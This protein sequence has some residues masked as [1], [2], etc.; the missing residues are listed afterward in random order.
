MRIDRIGRGPLFAD[1]GPR[2][3]RI[4]RR[5]RGVSIELLAFALTTL[6]LP[7]LVPIAL[8]VD[9]VLWVVRRKPW[10]AIRLLAIGW[11]FLAVEIRALAG[12]AWI[13]LSAGGPLGIGSE[14]RRRGVYELRINWARRH[15]GGISRVL[16]LR[17][18]VDGLEQ[19]GPGPVLIMIRH[20]SII[21]NLL[22]DALIAAEHRLGLRYVI[23]RELQTIPTIDIAGRWVPTNYVRRGSGDTAGELEAVR[24]LADDLGEDE[25]ILIYPEGT[26]CTSEKLARA[27]QKIA[28]SR[29][30]IAPL[31]NQLQNLLPPRLGGP[32][33]LLEAAAGVDVVICAHVGFDGFQHVSHVWGGGLVGTR[34]EVLIRRYPAAEVP[35]DPD[36]RTAWLYQR[37]QEL[38]D[39]VGERRAR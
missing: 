36:E 39:W 22:P 25:G 18:E 20:A 13:W 38:D 15:L 34:I 29:P 7:L 16:G 27:K 37:W 10:M 31:A 14:R 33:V 24:T 8:L 1:D 4:I 11:W 30:D 6:L 5:V 3:A 26:R 28:A 23:K 35:N 17:F 2:G 21:D 32:L 12:V 9:L 19:A